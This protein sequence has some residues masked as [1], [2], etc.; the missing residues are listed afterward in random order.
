MTIQAQDDGRKEIQVFAKATTRKPKL[1]FEEFNG[2]W[3]EKRLGEV[4]KITTGKLDANAM[5]KNGQYRF[6]TCAKNFFKINYKIQK[7]LLFL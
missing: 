3:E 7:L 5:V 2:E 1:R 6:Y 4:C